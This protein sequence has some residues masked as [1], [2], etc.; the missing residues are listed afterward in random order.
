[1]TIGILRDDCDIIFRNSPQSRPAGI[2]RDDVCCWAWDV[3]VDGLDIL[4]AVLGDDLGLF[5]QGFG[6]HNPVGERLLVGCG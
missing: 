1:M 3:L 4:V 2:G 5:V 6:L